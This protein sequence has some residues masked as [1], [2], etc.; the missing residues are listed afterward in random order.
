MVPAERL[1][2]G[3]IEP[4]DLAQPLQRGAEE[5]ARDAL[6]SPDADIDVVGLRKDRT[7][8]A[9]EVA[10]I[11]GYDA[12]KLAGNAARERDVPLERHRRL[13]GGLKA[14]GRRDC[15]V[16]AVGTDHHACNERLAL[17]G[18]RVLSVVAALDAADDLTVAKLDA[19]LLRTL[20]EIVIEAS[21]LRHVRKRALVAADDVTAP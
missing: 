16:R 13:G 2:A 14:E 18:D 3:R 15:A 9:G 5:L 17:S 6:P 20:D 21:A 8:A 12:A 7:V 11:Q 19:G 4:I 1:Q 10:K